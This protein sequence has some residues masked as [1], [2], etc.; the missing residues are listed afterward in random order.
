MMGPGFGDAVGRAAA[1]FFIVACVVSA[2]VGV[3]LWQLVA[4]LIRH[5]RIE[6]I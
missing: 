1:T 6:W 3:G 5:I 2:G 4:W